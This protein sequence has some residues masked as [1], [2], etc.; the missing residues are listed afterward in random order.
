MVK[1][2]FY[3]EYES[4]EDPLSVEEVLEAL[5]EN[6]IIGDYKGFFTVKEVTVDA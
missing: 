2:I 6:L 1:Q 3:V 5:T 4:E